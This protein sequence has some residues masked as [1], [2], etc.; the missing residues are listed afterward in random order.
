MRPERHPGGTLGLVG[1]DCGAG[2]SELLLVAG[3][4]VDR[5]DRP[6]LI[7]DQMAKDDDAS[8]NLRR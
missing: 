7:E 4:E 1:R 6:R 2:L 5:V 3:L 8:T